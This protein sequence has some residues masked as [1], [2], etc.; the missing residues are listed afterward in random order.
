MVLTRRTGFSH[1]ARDMR[2]FVTGGGMSGGGV[3]ADLCLAHFPIRHG[4][5]TSFEEAA[6]LGTGYRT[7]SSPQQCGVSP[8]AGRRW[9]S[10]FVV[11]R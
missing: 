9:T 1:V 2:V 11:I 6:H 8:D 7:V 10:V 4:R 5:R 3:K